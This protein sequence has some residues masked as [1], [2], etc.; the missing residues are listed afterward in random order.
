[1]QNPNQE[2]PND[3]KNYAKHN[4]CKDMM[5]IMHKSKLKNKKFYI[6]NMQELSKHM[7]RLSL[8]AWLYDEIRRTHVRFKKQ[9]CK[10]ENRN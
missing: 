3:L 8:D 10:E 2:T 4:Q 9:R 7:K 5:I 1:M 6:K